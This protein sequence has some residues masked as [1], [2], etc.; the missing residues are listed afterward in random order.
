MI[1]WINGAFGAGKTQTAFELHRR[2]PNSFVYDPENVGYFI[3]SNLPKSIQT[4]DFQDYEMW[5]QFNYAMIAY[6]DQKYEG[7]L[8]MPMTI[9][10]PQYFQEI[11]GELRQQGVQ[12]HHFALMAS[13]ETLIRRL[14]SRGDGKNSWPAQQ[15][16]RCL[17]GLSK[18]VFRHHIQTDHMT[19]EAVAE[20]I[21]ARS[22]IT[23][24]PD[25]SGKMMKKIKRAI[26]QWKHI[27][28]FS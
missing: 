14:R 23:L 2:I 8:I 20:K 19:I 5:R 27:R 9:V 16:D 6:M 13:E 26:T 3:R 17:L 10:N 18:D 11:I 21:A 1:I 28:F 4:S 25:P 22:G 12:I 24:L 7:T 15:I